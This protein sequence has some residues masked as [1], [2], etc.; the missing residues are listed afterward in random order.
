MAAA[1]ASSPASPRPS[2]LR[3]GKDDDGGALVLILARWGCGPCGDGGDWWRWG[4]NGGWPQ[5]A[6]IAL[7]FGGIWL[8]G[9]SSQFC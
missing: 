8:P 7:V 9:L 2:P 1:A 5:L 3:A 6:L 4:S